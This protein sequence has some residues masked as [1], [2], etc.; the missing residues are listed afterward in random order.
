MRKVWQAAILLGALSASA[1]A[2]TQESVVESQ[3][4]AVSTAKNPDPF[5]KLNRS[6]FKF[7]DAADRYFLRPIAVTYQKITPQ[8]VDNGITNFF[9]NLGEP[10]TVMNQVLQGKLLLAVKDTGR[11][12]VNSTAGVL[13]FFDVARHIKLERHNEDF[14][15]TLGWWGVPS[16]PYITLPF[17]GPSTIRD[18]VGFGVDVYANPRR[19]RLDWEVDTTLAVVD[20]VDTRADLIQVEQIMQGDKYLFMRDLYLQRRDFLVNDGQVQDSFMDDFEEEFIDEPAADEPAA[21][22]EGVDADGA[23][24]NAVEGFSIEPVA[25]ADAAVESLENSIEAERSETKVLASE[26]D[27]EV[28]Q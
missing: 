25:Q 8:P 21:V 17:M 9:N 18:A 1:H 19:D 5:E 11:F 3:V 7:N 13:G 20:V 26:D 4:D 24:N 14:G 6:V 16:G 22:N 15:Q 28:V 2:E 10:I 12:V 27:A 23:D